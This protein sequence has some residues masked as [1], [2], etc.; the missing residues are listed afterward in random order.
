VTSTEALLESLARTRRTFAAAT[1]SPPY[2][3]ISALQSLQDQYPYP[4]E[5][6]YDADTLERRGVGRAAQILGLPGAQQAQSF[7]ELACSDGMVSW[8]LCRAGKTATAIDASSARFD[9]RAPREGVNLLEMDATDLRLGTESVDF[10]FSYNAFEHFA[11]P[12]GVLR[13]AL[14]VVKKGG[15]IYL[16]FGPLYY[17]P[18]GEHAYRSITVPY[19]QFLFPKDL[20]NDFATQHGL[21]PIDFSHVNG[22]SLESYR[23]LWRKYSHVLERVIY[24]ESVDLSHLGMIGRYPSCFKSKSSYFENFIVANIRVLFRKSDHEVPSSD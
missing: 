21:T 18:F 22:W 9:E 23:G 15:H 4:P 24:R 11:S 14:R 20:I 12:E 19:C 6:G 16:E 10:V 1:S 3:D 13:E 17:S 7:L 8:G 2:L 5:Y